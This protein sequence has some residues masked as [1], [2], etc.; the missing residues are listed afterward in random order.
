MT[1]TKPKIPEVFV[2]TFCQPI[3]TYRENARPAQPTAVRTA[4][5]VIR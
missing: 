4:Y 2:A 1:E 3:V 5:C